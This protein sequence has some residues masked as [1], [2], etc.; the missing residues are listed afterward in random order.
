MKYMDANLRIRLAHQCPELRAAEKAAPLHIKS[1]VVNPLGIILDGVEYRLGLY[2]HYHNT[3]DLTNYI[4]EQNDAGGAQEDQ[5][6]YGIPD[7][8]DQNEL[9]P[10]DI[11]LEPLEDM[12]ERDDEAQ[13]L[14]L[15]QQLAENSK[16]MNDCFEEFSRHRKYGDKLRMPLADLERLY[17]SKQELVLKLKSE[18]FPYY[19][20]KNNSEVPFTQFIQL[21]ISGLPIERVEYT[22]SIYEAEKSLL[23]SIFGERAHPI[24]VKFLDIG[25]DL[26]IF[27]APEGLKLKVSELK[28]TGN[29]NKKIDRLLPILHESSFPLEV[30]HT[31]GFTKIYHH[32]AAKT[33]R[34]IRITDYFRYPDIYELSQ[35]FTNEE[36]ILRFRYI[37]VSALMEV[38]QGCM[39][40]G[41]NK[42]LSVEVPKEN[43][44]KVFFNC[45]NKQFKG[46]EA[47]ERYVLVPIDDDDWIKIS[48]E[49]AENMDGEFEWK[50]QFGSGDMD[51]SDDI[52]QK[53]NSGFECADF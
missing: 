38:A 17:N 36:V 19:Y 30:F 25:R 46:V 11:E 53:R 1:L 27:R 41:M 20:K 48:Y 4:K 33:A 10:G 50:V 26:M 43:I 6:E 31:D 52:R 16:I 44:I 51:Q 3:Q 22:Q 8:S 7:Y 39:S 47:G 29:F 9:Y 2:R 49:R 5:D 12:P 35:N 13:R 24:Q 40:T 23:F 14:E 32:K 18:L 42:I 45:M 15:E 34:K 28:V 37:S 21:S